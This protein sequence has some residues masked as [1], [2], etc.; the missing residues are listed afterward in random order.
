MFMQ[1]YESLWYILP[2][3]LMEDDE[4]ET[5]RD[6]APVRC[7]NEG[8][9]QFD[10]KVGTDM[11]VNGEAIA[12]NDSILVEWFAGW[13]LTECEKFRRFNVIS[14]AREGQREVERKEWIEKWS[15][16][17]TSYFNFNSKCRNYHRFLIDSAD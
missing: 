13:A 4:F 11:P 10:L 12:K 7:M 2:Q 16:V 15:H 5:P 8:V 14:G 6:E 9:L 17:S 3:E 1:I